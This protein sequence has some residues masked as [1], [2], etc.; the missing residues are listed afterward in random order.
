V[1]TQNSHGRIHIEVTQEDIKRAEVGNSFRCVV[2][3]A[4]AR[5]IP[6]ATRIEVDSQ[7]I[8]WTQDGERQ[9][10]LCPYSVSGYIVAFDA[11]DPPQPFEFRL[12]PRKR[13]PVRK[14]TT[15]EAGKARQ[16]AKAAVARKQ[17][18]RDRI[19][20]DIETERATP[21]QLAEAEAELQQAETD[22]TGVRA[23]Y[24]GQAQMYREKGEG[25]TK[26]PQRVYKKGKREFGMRVLRINRQN[27]EGSS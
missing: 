20:R 17:K 27:D 3:Q 16:K 13:F 9:V 12:D 22:L 26:A 21:I 15:T 2:R 7:T 4:I 23:A 6:G 25:R 18:K 19:A 1:T 14:Q 5:T 11:G 10:Y 24:I 8:R